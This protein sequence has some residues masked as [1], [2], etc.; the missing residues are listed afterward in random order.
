M[1]YD[2]T[3]CVTKC[4]IVVWVGRLKRYFS[5]L[6]IVFREVHVKFIHIMEIISSFF[7]T[8]NM[9]LLQYSI[10]KNVIVNWKMRDCVKRLGLRRMCR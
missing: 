3:F 8:F 2:I 5:I 9:Y 6:R 1:S 7:H 4:N 10:L